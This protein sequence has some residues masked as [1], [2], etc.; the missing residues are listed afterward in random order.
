MDSK[1]PTAI[2]PAVDAA[3]KPQSVK[4]CIRPICM[5]FNIFMIMID[6]AFSI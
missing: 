2:W 4:R 3:W 5:Y 1:G 6:K